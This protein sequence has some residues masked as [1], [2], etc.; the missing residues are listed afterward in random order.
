MQKF[1]NFA[2]HAALFL[3]AAIMIFPIFW[4]GL[5]SVKQYPSGYD[6][7]GEI[8]SAPTTP[9]NYGDILYPPSIRE[10]KFNL[11]KALGADSFLRYF[12]NSAFVSFAVTAGN[13][14][15]CLLCGYALARR[16]FPGKPL[17]FASVLGVLI[18]PPHVIMIP[19][20]R[21]MAQ[22]NWIDTY[23]ALIIPWLVAPFGVFLM[24]QY[25]ENLP[26]EIED[27]A[28]IDG[29]G[30]WA[31]IFKVVAPLS[32]PM[33]TALAIYIFLTNWNTF[34]FPFL[35]TND[36]SMRT[37]PVGLALYLDKQSL[38][39]GR[40]MAGAAVSAAPVL[41]LFALFQKKIIRGL[42]AGALKE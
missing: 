13:V 30:D 26:V 3:G 29:A 4:M 34:L 40:F 27:A 17:L 9:S 6:G 38:D 18:I 19:L 21:M 2:I 33:L 32:R 11:F 5:L 37:I 24:K 28:R 8:V 14:F 35:F 39:W 1:K 25:A 16:E 7:I 31:V 12:V 36:A 20:F 10:D 23:Y 22:L 42:T 41:I 15:F